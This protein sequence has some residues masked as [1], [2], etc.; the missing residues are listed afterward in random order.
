M[1]K[2]M[3]PY[4]LILF[5]SFDDEEDVIFFCSE[6]FPTLGLSSVK[7][8]I[9]GYS[10]MVISFDSDM[11]KVELSNALF[12]ILAVE[13]IKIYYLFERD[14]VIS[15]CMPREM[16]NFLYRR[17][18]S[19]GDLMKIEYGKHT[20]KNKPQPVLDEILEKIERTGVESLSED[21]K[22]FLDNFGN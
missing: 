1:G 5:A 13:Y 18:E 7:Y 10:H 3:T 16:I 20:E 9:E 15:T 14:D 4:V 11:G 8:V 2:R 22:N 19:D 17:I 6:V 21:E 12:D